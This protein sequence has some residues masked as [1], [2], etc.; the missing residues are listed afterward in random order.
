VLLL[1]PVLVAPPALAAQ[2]PPNIA[3]RLGHPR[4]ARLLILHA[5][6]LGMM[7]SVNRATFEALERVFL[8]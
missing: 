5:D 6:D 1:A 3:E 8:G 4:D 7:R 2:E